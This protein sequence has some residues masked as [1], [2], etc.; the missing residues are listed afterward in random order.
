MPPHAISRP[1][2]VP[3][4]YSDTDV[5]NVTASRARVGGLECRVGQRDT[6]IH[7]VTASRVT[8]GS[9]GFP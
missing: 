7:N 5:H 1:S 6:D 8:P 4:P 9:P 3:A 2:R